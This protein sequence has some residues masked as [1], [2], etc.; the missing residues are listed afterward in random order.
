M[1]QRAMAL[2]A[3]MNKFLSRDARVQSKGERLRA[4]RVKRRRAICLLARH[5]RQLM[6]QYYPAHKAESDPRFAEINRGIR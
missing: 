3:K 5:L 4:G 1:R 2:R 6:D